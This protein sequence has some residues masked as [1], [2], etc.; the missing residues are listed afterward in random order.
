MKKTP[1][2]RFNSVCRK[3]SMGTDEGIIN[4]EQF[5]FWLKTWNKIKNEDGGFLEKENQQK[6]LFADINDQISEV[7][8]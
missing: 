8:I 3:L 4:I 6:T 7:Q 1:D 5:E 2:H